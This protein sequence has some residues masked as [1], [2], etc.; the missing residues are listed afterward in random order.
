MSALRRRGPG[1]FLALA[2][3]LALL[4]ACGFQPLYG[5][6]PQGRAAVGAELAQISVRTEPDRLGQRLYERLVRQLG[7]AAEPRYH[8][9]VELESTEA[10]AAIGRDSRA[11]RFD[12]TVSA[13][14]RLN[15]AE[16]GAQLYSSRA[17]AVSSYNLVQSDFAT[18]I[19]R[20]DAEERATDVVS[21][22]IL[23][24]IAILFSRPPESEN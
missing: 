9:F 20:R 21:E 8:L 15:A 14:Y 3:L 11:R 12:V 7:Y 4:A 6:R 17:R 13:R 1:P 5:D 18:E 22:T 19:A 10:E 2:G 16:T 24:Q 23:T